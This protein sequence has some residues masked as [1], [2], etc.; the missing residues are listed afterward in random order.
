MKEQAKSGNVSGV[1]DAGYGEW[2]NS[3]DCED[4]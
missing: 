1:P 3:I 2:I 4:N